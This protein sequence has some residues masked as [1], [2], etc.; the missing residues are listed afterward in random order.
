MTT[1][2]RSH[3]E[4]RRTAFWIAPAVGATAAALAAAGLLVLDQYVG[5]RDAPIPVFAG[6][7][8]TARELLTTIATSVT[9][10]IALVFTILAVVIQLAS[11]QY[12]PRALHTLLQDRPTHL[13]I[14]VFV[15]TFTYCLVLLLAFRVTVD[16]DGAAGLALT[17]AFVLAVL[18]IGTF[19]IYSNH[20]IHAVR[21]TQILDRIAGATHAIIERHFRA[22]HE[23]LTAE[24]KGEPQDEACREVAAPKSGLVVDFN[25]DKL[26][27]L[28]CRERLRI[29]V[30]PP[31][32]A[33]VPE[34]APVLAVY[35]KRSAPLPDLT[36]WIRISSERTLS[37]D[38]GFGLRQLIDVAARALST[39]IN[40]PATAVQVLDHVHGLLRTL[41]GRRLGLVERKDGDAVRLSWR[42]PAWENLLDMA[43]DELRLFTGPSLQVHQR[44][45]ALLE[46]LA[47]V[48]PADRRPSIHRQLEL[49]DASV[50]RSFP[51][52][53][54]REEARKPQPG[55][56]SF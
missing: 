19:A 37:R 47:D 13:T 40:D 53:S 22:P 20:I 50:E 32:G 6:D 18:S 33:Y 16:D 49:L 14:G 24:S 26:F 39:G 8:S 55:G 36:D 45:R 41:A 30:L 23:G 2:K 7:E 9:T 28:A 5:F 35:G 56:G 46:D 31:V 51:D 52:P 3:A 21:I 4:A 29:R 38:L 54:V 11:S 17:F 44:L 15:G 27:V 1:G 10:L 12:S 25:E 42:T 34:G 48:A 43:V